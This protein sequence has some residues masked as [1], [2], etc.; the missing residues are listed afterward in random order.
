MSDDLKCQ[1]LN[2]DC[3]SF[4]L[5]FKIIVVGDSGVGKSCLTIKASR[6]YFE[7]YYSPTVGF[8][9]LT[10][11][12]KIQDQ[13]IKLQIWD[14]CGQ[15]VYKSLIHSFYRNASMAFIAYA[16]D[17]EESFNN[18][19]EWLNDIKTQSNPDIK[20][21]MVGTKAD[22][23]DKRKITKERAE[24]FANEH[25]MNFFMETSA[26]TGFNV[27]NLFIH[28]AKILY[29]ENLLVKDK[30]SRPGSV[31]DNLPY[32]P[33]NNVVYLENDESD[34]PRKKKGCC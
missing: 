5:S 2:D 25:K 23:E 20:I 28:A 26:K 14:T 4:D 8:E 21:F 6:N 13:N 3:Q 19:E 9:F 11:N 17:N 24:E 15:E 18:I 10:F 1:V 12:V 32:T 31:A 30:F 16:I 7:D 22:L 27:Q 34:K 29:E 33:E